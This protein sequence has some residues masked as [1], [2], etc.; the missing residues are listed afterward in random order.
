MEVGHIV[1]FALQPYPYLVEVL[2][3]LDLDCSCS[4]VTLT[5][6]E[7]LPPGSRPRDCLRFTLRVCLHTWTEIEPPPRSLEVESLA[8]EFLARF[9]DQRIAE[10]AEAFDQARTTQARLKS[11]SLSGSRDKLVTYSDVMDE[12]GGVREGVTEHSFF[13]VFEGREFLVEDHYCANPE[14]DCGMVHLEFWERVHEI[15]PK[16]GITLRQQLMA[17]FTL[18][19]ELTET[20]FSQE[21]SSRTQHLL[22]AWVRRCSEYFSE[23]RRRYE[24]IKAVGAKSFPPESKSIAPVVIARECWPERNPQTVDTP[25]QV[26]RND[27]CPCGSGLKFKRCCARRP[28]VID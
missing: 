19:G 28:A 20:R 23:F 27:P 1:R 9:P 25:R 8:R 10:L 22:Q 12:R 24:L 2:P 18:A 15:Y 7:C 11:L 14:C 17:T 3:C 6:S 16:R 4:V 5:L 13:F 26:R 21:S